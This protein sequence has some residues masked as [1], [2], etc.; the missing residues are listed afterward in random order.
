MLPMTSGKVNFLVVQQYAALLIKHLRLII[1]LLTLG[2]T[3]GLFYYT[4]AR[5]VFSAQATFQVIYQ[6]L[7]LDTEGVFKDSNPQSIWYGMQ[8]PE[9]IERA[10]KNLGINAK[11]HQI[12]QEHLKGVRVVSSDG[13]FYSIQVYTYSTDR[14]DQWPE[15]IFNAFIELRREGRAAQVQQRLDSYLREIVDLDAQIDDQRQRIR[16]FET[17]KPYV[18]TLSKLEQLQ[19]TPERL[20]IVNQRI[21]AYEDARRILLSE[22]LTPEEIISLVSRLENSLE[23]GTELPDQSEIPIR[24][25]PYSGDEGSDEGV[26]AKIWTEGSTSLSPARYKALKEAYAKAKEEFDA[27]ASVYRPAHPKYAPAAAA[28]EVAEKELKGSF[29][30]LEK[31]YALEYE[32]L[33][34]QRRMLEDR[35]ALLRATETR[36]EELDA[37]LRNLKGQGLNWAGMRVRLVNELATVDYGKDNERATF[38]F[39][40]LQAVS[41]YPISPSRYKMLVY[42]LGLGGIL[43]VSIPF[44]LEFLDHTISE[45]ESVERNL[46]VQPLGIIPRYIE[47]EPTSQVREDRLLGSDASEDGDQDPMRLE[48]FRVI[49]AN[50]L[51]NR[52]ITQ[53]RQVVLVTSALPREGKSHTAWS[54]AMSFA[55]GGERTLLLDA[56]V[57]R[58]R[59]HRRFGIDS[60]PGLSDALAKGDTDALSYCRPTAYAHLDV[61]PCGTRTSRFPEILNNDVMSAFIG[62]LRGTYS[63]II[64][65][66]TP[67]LGLAE[68]HSLLPHVDGVVLVIWS[69]NTP[70]QAVTDAVNQLSSNGANFYGFLLNQVDMRV[71]TNYHR[72]YYYS[73]YYYAS[74]APDAD[75]IDPVEPP[76]AQT[77]TKKDTPDA[78]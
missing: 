7:P 49:R 77:D 69:G 59:Q 31:R 35:L 50:F 26:S 16:E 5:P 11:V 25:S 38:N 10:A 3:C 58:G 74:Y 62:T 30:E 4:Y 68:T 47:E 36:K 45:T 63:R 43:A 75:D 46:G 13:G 33:L 27:I 67:V 78:S 73:K 9:V 18:E 8:S 51:S 41:L 2:L 1:L 23:I 24:I 53:G 60:R 17:S 12:M 32:F 76:V 42:S 20:V 19:S 15:A 57:R 21:E 55:N 61:L 48:T 22:T 70:Q 54:L 44:L 56:D 40:G 66:S 52:A 37:E 65:D 39:I 28:L 6:P 71:A 72:F 34:K 14:T 64:V 29:E